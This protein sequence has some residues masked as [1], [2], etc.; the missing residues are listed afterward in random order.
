[1]EYIARTSDLRRL[2]ERFNAEMEFIFVGIA[3]PELRVTYSIVVHDSGSEDSGPIVAEV[4]EIEFTEID[5]PHGH[6]GVSLPAPRNIVQTPTGVRLSF[7]EGR[8]STPMTLALR[9]APDALRA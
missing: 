7:D 2:T 3:Q 1:M 5:D 8:G 9:K 6:G 4:T